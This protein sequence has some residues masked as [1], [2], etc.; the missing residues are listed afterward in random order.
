[1]TQTQPTVTVQLNSGTHYLCTCNASKNSPFCDGSHKG[2]QFQPIALELET[3]K[4]VEVT[5]SMRP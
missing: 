1:M 4:T 2:S 3:P 5:G